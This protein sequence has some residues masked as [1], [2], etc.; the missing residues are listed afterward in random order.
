MYLAKTNETKGVV[1]NVKKVKSK[2]IADQLEQNKSAALKCLFESK[3]PPR[4]YE[5]SENIEK[6]RVVKMEI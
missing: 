5:N 4:Y 3:K 6:A 1:A 2:K